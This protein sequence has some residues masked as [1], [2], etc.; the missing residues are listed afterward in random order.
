MQIDLKILADECTCVCILTKSTLS[1]Q[2]LF[3][4]YYS[5]VKGT[6]FLGEVAD[7][8]TG[9]GKEQDNPGKQCARG[10]GVLK[11]RRDMSEGQKSLFEGQI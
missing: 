10:K 7:S 3:S 8:R 1:A 2:V 6:G 5:P 11:E 4:K 9:T